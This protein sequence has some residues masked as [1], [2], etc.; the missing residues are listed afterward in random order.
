MARDATTEDGRAT[1]RVGLLNE[2]PLHAALK[3]WYAEDGDR[4]EVP[5][6]GFVADIVRDG[7]LIEIQ[8]TSASRLRRKISALVRRH[9]V[10]LVLPVAAR[11]TIVRVDEHGV[12]QSRRDS[13]RRATA[14]DAFRELV[15][16]G[17]LLGDSNLAVDIV[18]V[19]EEEVRH[20]S[21]RRKGFVVGERRLVAVQDCVSL[22]H[23][24]DYLGILPSALRDDFTTADLATALRQPRWMAQKIAYV[25]RTIGVVRVVGKAGNAFLY[26]RG[27]GL[28]DGDDPGT[29]ST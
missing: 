4:F 24:A 11:K 25:L 29:I 16:L 6:D 27:S 19:H 26:R 13:R 20:E 2:K 12:E 14:L 8:T 10:R 28:S 1:A 18:L 21:A 9:K 3:L 22:D 7:A 23:P 15:G 5:V 17:D